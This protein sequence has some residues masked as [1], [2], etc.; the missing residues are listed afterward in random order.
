[1]KKQLGFSLLEIFISMIIGI[2]LFSGV[3]AIF[4]GM[5]TT[6]DDTSRYGAM[7]ETGRFVISVLSEDLMRQGYMGDLTVPLSR[8]VL[9]TNPPAAPGGQCIG[10]GINNGALPGAIGHFRTLWGITADSASNMNCINDAEIDSD[11][12]FLKRTITRP[13]TVQNAGNYYL[14]TNLGM[15]QLVV[16][17]SPNPGIDNS[18]IYEYVNHVY[19]V[20]K[21]SF[22][23]ENVPQ[24]NMMTLG[25]SG[26]NKQPLV[27]GIERIR[28]LYG[29]DIGTT[30]RPLDGDVDAFVS[31]DEMNNSFSGSNSALGVYWDNDNTRIL[32]V[33]IYVLVRDIEEDKKY[34]NKTTYLLGDDK[35]V[36]PSDH[37]RRM[38]FSSTVTLFNNDTEVWQ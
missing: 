21:E 25:T 5:K 38:L 22:G 14:Y 31:A 2:V 15:G 23:N 24:L 1:M 16:G 27:D 17:L 8:S 3:L 20:S 18:N 36:A 26:M 6:A 13:A 19:Y 12:L 11:I 4:V 30:A 32:A 10:D 9:L 28:F 35:F 7:Q 29:L 33:K 37:Y 34:T